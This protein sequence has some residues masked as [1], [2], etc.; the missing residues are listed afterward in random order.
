M[1]FLFKEIFFAMSIKIVE[2]P[3]SYE[4]TKIQ[5][6]MFKCIYHKYLLKI[7]QFIIFETLALGLDL[8]NLMGFFFHTRVPCLR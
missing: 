7:F 1:Q 3:Y 8:N 6:I 4:K 5:K 2:R